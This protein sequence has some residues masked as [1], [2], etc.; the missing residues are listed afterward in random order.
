MAAKLDLTGQRYGQLVVLEEAEPGESKSGNRLR[1]WLCQCDCGNKKVIWQGVLR[2][3][4]TKSCGCLNHSTKRDWML[5]EQR[6]EWERQ[7]KIGDIVKRRPV[8]FYDERAGKIDSL[9]QGSVVYIHP[10]GRYHTVA[11]PVWGGVI[12]ESF[13]GVRT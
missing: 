9:M 12:R 3:G 6:R 4:R 11:F 10:K 2:A 1:R 7:V 8:T 13:K 5:D